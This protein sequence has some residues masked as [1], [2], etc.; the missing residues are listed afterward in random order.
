MSY[1]KHKIAAVVVH[2]LSDAPHASL[3]QLALEIGT[4]RQTVTRAL[5]EVLGCSF[6]TLRRRVLADLIQK[7]ATDSK[8]S[9][10]K[11]VSLTLGYSHPRS[12][13]R[14]CKAEFG[15]SYT[16]LRDRE[17]FVDPRARRPLG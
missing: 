11:E 16:S 2:R 17:R 5:T 7:A 9:T 13:S 14:A 3:D 6:R 1:S 8:L 15:V 4:T 12:L 10:A